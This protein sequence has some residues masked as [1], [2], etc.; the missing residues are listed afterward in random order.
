MR[1]AKIE[2][3]SDVYQKMFSDSEYI[4]CRATPPVLKWLR[5]S[6]EGKSRH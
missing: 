4:Y 6:L 2:I 5:Q 1:A 3:A